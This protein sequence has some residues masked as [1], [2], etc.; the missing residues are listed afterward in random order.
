MYRLP[1]QDL[2]A[3]EIKVF[4]YDATPF[5][6]G[7]EK[8]FGLLGIHFAQFPEEW[9]LRAGTAKSKRITNEVPLITEEPMS[10]GL[11]E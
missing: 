10:R 8:I 9:E 2:E 4:P 1:W 3:A 11:A 5:A 7:M 6:F